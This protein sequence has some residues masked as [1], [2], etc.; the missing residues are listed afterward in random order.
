MKTKKNFA[1][2]LSLNA[3]TL[4]IIGISALIICTLINLL[5][6]KGKNQTLDLIAL[7]GCIA[8]ILP[9]FLLQFAMPSGLL[10]HFGF[11]TDIP[12]WGKA[13][14]YILVF[15]FANMWMLSALDSALHFLPNFH[16]AM[17]QGQGLLIVRAL[18]EQWQSQA[19]LIIGISYFAMI[20]A[21]L[22]FREIFQNKLKAKIA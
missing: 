10:N 18:R 9:F 5:V 12:F 3:S 19:W 11:Q 20:G 1:D 7:M 21:G 16:E 17:V 4:T 8:F 13:M 6:F 15:P 14:F 2:W 22:L